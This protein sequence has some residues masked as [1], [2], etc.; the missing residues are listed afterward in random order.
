M[1]CYPP[2]IMRSSWLKRA[3]T[4]IRGKIEVNKIWVNKIEDKKIS[5]KK[6]FDLCVN[7]APGSDC[8]TDVTIQLTSTYI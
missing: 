8:R 4:E 6:P 2:W 1:L 5:L 7:F 3:D